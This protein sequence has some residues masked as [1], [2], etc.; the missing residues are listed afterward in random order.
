MEVAASFNANAILL[1][2]AAG[3]VTIISLLIFRIHL[4]SP[5]YFHRARLY[6]VFF[7]FSN[8]RTPHNF[9]CYAITSGVFMKEDKIPQKE[10]KGLHLLLK[11]IRTQTPGS[12]H[13]I[14][15]KKFEV[16]HKFGKCST[17]PF[18]SKKIIFLTDVWL[19]AFW[20]CIC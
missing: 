9:K 11:V 19:L 18:P 8:R 13:A 16:N 12:C 14:H 3:N 1:S 10:K 20:I 15:R 6:I 4:R 7:L 5:F 17:G 2:H